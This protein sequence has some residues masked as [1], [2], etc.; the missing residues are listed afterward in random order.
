MTEANFKTY[1]RWCSG[2]FLGGALA[3]AAVNWA[4]DPLQFYRKAGYP[5][6]LLEQKRFQAPGLAKHYDYDTLI[7]GTSMSENFQPQQVA[8]KLGG[9]ALNL[10]MQGASVREQSLAVQVALRAGRAQ[11]VLWELNYE[12]LRGN[13]QWVANFDGTFPFYFYDQNA[14]NEI[15]HY[16][17]SVDTAKHSLKILLGRAGLRPYRS[18]PPEEVFSW[19]R[20]K[21]F[22]PASVRKAWQRAV[23]AR[24][25]FRKLLP[26]LAAEHL[27]ANFDR[28]ILPL[29]RGHP[30][31]KFDLF[32]PPFLAAYYANVREVSPQILT[33]LLANRRHIFAQTRGLPNVELHDFQTAEEIVFS[34][35]DYCDLMHFNLRVN[36]LI[37]EAIRDGRHRMTDADSRELAALLAG[38]RLANWAREHG[39]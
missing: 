21:D 13:P 24:P 34:L 19:H 17:L 20:G 1:L 10:S 4:V 14:L 33:N 30:D 15:N 25:R 26:D 5:P 8:A 6:L 31:V 37:L 3:M 7:M 27:N 12:Y 29:L 38:P 9:Q 28:H 2:L 23:E 32:F 22:G 18:R 16:L 36:E 11:R 35:E 39:E